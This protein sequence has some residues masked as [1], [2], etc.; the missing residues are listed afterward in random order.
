MPNSA[1]ELKSWQLELF[2]GNYYSGQPCPFAGNGRRVQRMANV[3]NRYPA[4]FYS[5]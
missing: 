5:Y 4:G 2:C 3:I 1:D